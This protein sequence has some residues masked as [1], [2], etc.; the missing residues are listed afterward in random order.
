MTGKLLAAAMMIL[1]GTFTASLFQSDEE[2]VRL[3]F[4]EARTGE[5][6]LEAEANKGD[7][8]TFSWIHS[9]EKT[10]WNET[11]E[12]QEDNS[13]LLKS[14][15]FASYGAGVPHQKG[16]MKIENGLIT[17]D[18]ID[19]HIDNLSWIHSHEANHEMN[20]NN[21]IILSVNDLPHH[22]AIRLT[23]KKR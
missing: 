1:A 9:V 11:Y 14:T 13:L 15:S 17:Y 19:E 3:I 10:P 16:E 2:H 4:E 18:N 20:L 5:V 8:L 7:R 12:I 6:L 22:E 23:V 21:E